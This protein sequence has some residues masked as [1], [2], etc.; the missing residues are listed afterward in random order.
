MTSNALMMISSKRLL[1]GSLNICS[2]LTFNLVNTN[3]F[4]FIAKLN[5]AHNVLEIWEGIVVV[6]TR[7]T[8]LIISSML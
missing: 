3:H 1:I 8:Q 2:F 4:W 7:F 6:C 5:P